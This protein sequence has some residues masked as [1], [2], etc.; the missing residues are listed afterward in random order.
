MVTFMLD[1]L[2]PGEVIEAQ[3][4]TTVLGSPLMRNSFDNVTELA[5]QDSQGAT[6][7]ISAAARVPVV[8]NL[9]PTGY[10]VAA[11]SPA[12]GALI[13]C[14]LG[15]TLELGLVLAVVMWRRRKARS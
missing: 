1:D 6:F 15:L 2:N 14:A 5:G 7:R 8:T 4:V 10:A 13:G 9:P 11:G 12:P 3:I